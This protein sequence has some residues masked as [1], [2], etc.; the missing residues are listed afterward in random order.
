MFPCFDPDEFI[1]SIAEDLE[2]IQRLKLEEILTR[3]ANVEYLQRHGL[4]G[5]TDVA[6]FKQCLPVVTYS[7]LEPDI[8]RLVNGDSTPIFNADPVSA[9]FLSTGTTAGKAKFIPTTMRARE[10]VPCLQRVFQAMLR[11]QIQGGRDAN[12]K[13]LNLGFAGPLRETPSGIKAGAMT[14]ILLYSALSRQRPFDPSSIN[15]SPD[16]VFFCSDYN[17]AMYCHL[18]C[19]LAQAPEITRLQAM[20]A[21]TVVGTVRLLQRCWPEL[22]NDIRN[23]T[24]NQKVSDPA[25]RKA[26]EQIL[27]KG[28]PE[29]ASMIE[30]QCSTHDW[31]HIIPR[32]WPN[33][34]SISCVL[35]GTMQQYVPALKHFAGHIP[36]ISPLYAA[37]ECPVIGLNVQFNHPPDAIGYMIWPESAYFEF[38]PISGTPEAHDLSNSTEDQPLQLVDAADVELGKEYEIVV[39]NVS[40][41][42]RYCVGDVLRVKGFRKK[43]PIFEFAQRKNVVLSIFTEKVD[44]EELQ[45]VV[46]KASQHLVETSMELADFSSTADILSSPGRYILFWEI[47]SMSSGTLDA[48]VLQKCANTLDISF[49]HLYKKWRAAGQIGALELRILKEGS[50]DQLMASAVLSRGISPGQFKTPRCIK[51]PSVLEILNSL[52]VATFQSHEKPSREH[53]I[54]GHSAFCGQ[55]QAVTG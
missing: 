33:M 11:K 26:V 34:L 24:L 7:D 12:G 51:A 28:D 3:N 47:I 45:G 43:A 4:N 10:I 27:M 18:L 54:A 31:G 13:I 55:I 35:S 50:F 32:I 53:W 2:V 39:T 48:E 40:G 1:D 38:I 21:V 25:T 41:L 30:T 46:N 15:S 16:E 9:F 23:G 37:S 20:F 44:E 19:A 29:L 49:N 17:Q 5:R 42:Y 6:S 36:L 14:S 22:C 52:V 8:L